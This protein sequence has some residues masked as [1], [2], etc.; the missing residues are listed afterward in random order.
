MVYV[1]GRYEDAAQGSPSTN[2]KQNSGN[3]KP[4]SHMGTQ[5]LPFGI[6]AITSDFGSEDTCSIQVTA[7]KT[8]RVR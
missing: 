4:P 1:F 8:E 6:K 7:T 2:K 5:I 3:F